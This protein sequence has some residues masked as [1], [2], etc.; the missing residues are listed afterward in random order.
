MSRRRA[1]IGIRASTV[2]GWE[3]AEVIVPNSMLV[4]QQV[5]NWTPSVYRRRL[6]IPVNVAYGTAPEEVL[7]VLADVATAH[8]DVA[9]APPPALFLGFGD[10][11]LG[12][13]CAPGRAPDRHV[14]V[15]TS[16]VAVYAAFRKAGMT[17]P[18]PQQEVRLHRAPA[19][20]AD[21]TTMPD[22]DREAG[23][24]PDG[25]RA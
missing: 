2:T 17:I 20:P 15:K 14:A 4:A 8:P 1:R 6:D 10:S 24:P 18:F 5:I 3:G 7:K 22:Q 21:D 25:G 16:S 23:R 11:A 9:A 19:G 13:S 12:S